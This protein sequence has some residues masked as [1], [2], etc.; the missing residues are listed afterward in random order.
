MHFC[1]WEWR[2]L[3]KNT[4]LRVKVTEMSN[5][6]LCRSSIIYSY[7]FRAIDLPISIRVAL[8]FGART[9]PLTM[10]VMILDLVSCMCVKII[11]LFILE[12]N[13][14][15]WD[16]CS[17]CVWCPIQCILWV[18]VDNDT[19]SAIIK[20]SIIT[21]LNGWPLDLILLMVW[22][23]VFGRKTVVNSPGYLCNHTCLFP[24]TAIITPY[25]TL[26]L[27]D[28]Q[29]SI[30]PYNPK[31]DVCFRWALFYVVCISYN[32]ITVIARCVNDWIW[33]SFQISVHCRNLC[34]IFH[35]F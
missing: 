11:W 18:R 6:V 20:R 31:L 8:G 4:I 21:K 13:Y 22:L 17:R 1:G 34:M 26:H 5:K 30:H 10:H 23:L 2:L 3:S 29:S 19:R 24:V 16:T 9:I 15:V 7:W 28:L 33:N 35:A 32:F 14:I 25:I 27:A 12:N